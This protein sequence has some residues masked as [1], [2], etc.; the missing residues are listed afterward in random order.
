ML[1]TVMRNRKCM[2]VSFGTVMYGE[3]RLV[4][5]DKFD[6]AT[7][8]CVAMLKAQ[9]NLLKGQKKLFNSTYWKEFE[10]ADPYVELVMR[11]QRDYNREIAARTEKERNTT[12]MFTGKKGG[13][14]IDVWV[15]KD[16]VF[17]DPGEVVLRHALALKKDLEQEVQ[18][19]KIVER[20][21]SWER[22]KKEALPWPL[23]TRVP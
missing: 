15:S 1:I 8:V 9:P 21:E 7:G 17:A 6:F 16:V 20:E 18:W 10:L 22:A 14:F 13:T 4:G 3:S 23:E 12:N 19:Q 5:D 2:R 11:H